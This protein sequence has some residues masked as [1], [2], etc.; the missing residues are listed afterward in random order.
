MAVGW[1]AWGDWWH[2]SQEVLNRQNVG[3]WCRVAR[4]LDLLGCSAAGVRARAA[5]HGDA[6]LRRFGGA[7]SRGRTALSPVC[8]PAE[9][10]PPAPFQRQFS[11]FWRGL[12]VLGARRSARKSSAALPR[13]PGEPGVPLLLLLLFPPYPG[14]ILLCG[15]L[16]GHL[17]IPRFCPLLQLRLQPW[18]WCFVALASSSP[19]PASALASD[20]VLLVVRL[21][22]LVAGGWWLR[23]L[24]G[25]RGVG[26]QEIGD[27]KINEELEKEVT[28]APGGSGDRE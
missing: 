22:R 4:V 27:R 16:F 19:T 23:G 3:R 11:C 24:R 10:A 20:L 28:L 9:A 13:R 2:G 12:D 18:C 25:L 17:T 14:R 7:A 26:V 15:S 5:D 1:G 21:V 6:L 8:A